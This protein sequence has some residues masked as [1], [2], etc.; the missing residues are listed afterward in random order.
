[1]YAASPVAIIA[2]AEGSM[3]VDYTIPLPKPSPVI[4]NRY[5]GEAVAGGDYLYLFDNGHIDIYWTAQGSAPRFTTAVNASGALDV[6]A[7]PKSFFTLSANMS[8]TSYS[9]AGAQLAQVTIDEG[10]GAEPISITT[11]G[12]AVWVTIAKGCLSGTCQRRTLVLDPK[13]LAVTASMNGGATDVVTSGSRAYALFTLPDEVRV[14]DIASPLQPSQVVA[15]ASPAQASSIAYFAGTVFVLAGRVY[16]YNEALLPTAEFL[17]SVASREQIAVDGDCAT[18][19]GS[20]AEFFTLP[21]WGPASL[22]IEIPSG[23]QAIASRPGRLYV[24]TEHSIEV[25]TTTPPPAPTRRR[26]SR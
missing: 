4:S 26:A 19:L 9:T 16:A 15:T 7:L 23:T 21:S 5:Y 24:L 20:S 1:M 3:A 14:V 12:D 8:V 6:A 10:A 25:W 13:T 22:A 11:A 17:S 18:I 2:G